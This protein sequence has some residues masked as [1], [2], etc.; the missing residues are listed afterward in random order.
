MMKVTKK[1]FV[2]AGAALAL[3]LYGSLAGAAPASAAIAPVSGATAIAMDVEPMATCTSWTPHMRRVIVGSAAVH[4]SY[5]GSSPVIAHWKSKTLFRIDKRCVNSAGNLW[6][7]SD[8]CTGVKGYIWNDYT[9]FAHY[10]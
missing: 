9:E 2:A 3:A 8:C 10:N 6:W 7:H 1:R 5:T 4:T